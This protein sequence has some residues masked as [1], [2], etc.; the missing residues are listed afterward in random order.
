M[1]PNG[2]RNS[3][4]EC[5]GGGVWDVVTASKTEDGLVQGMSGEAAA[6]DLNSAEG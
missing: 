6:K 2:Y 3:N 4:A 5:R 1:E